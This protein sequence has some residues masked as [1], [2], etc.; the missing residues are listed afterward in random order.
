MAAKKTGEADRNRLRH[1]LDAVEEALRFSKK[2]SA[3][4]LRNDRM[5]TLALIKDL[6]ILGEAAGKVSR[7]FRERH[8]GIPWT[9]MVAV[10]NRLIHGYFGVDVDIVWRTVRHDLPEL[11]KA[12]KA[13]LRRK[14]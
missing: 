9:P 13:I 2:K 12:L 10:R 1:M 6:E 7:G 8:P 4:E 11:A 3:E 14:D 5:L